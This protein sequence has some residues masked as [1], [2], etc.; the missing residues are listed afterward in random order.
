MVRPMLYSAHLSSAFWPEAAAYA[1]WTLLR[2]VP[3]RASSTSVSP[4]ELLHGA[5]PD[6]APAHQF[7]ALVDFRDDRPANKLAPR[8]RQ[9]LCMGVPTNTSFGTITI[10]ALDT[11]RTIETRDYSVFPGITPGSKL[12]PVN[13]ADAADIASGAGVWGTVPDASIEK[14][15]VVDALL[16]PQGP[17]PLTQLGVAGHDSPTMFSDSTN[18]PPTSPSS[19]PSSRSV[20]NDQDDVPGTGSQP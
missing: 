1:A 7:G 17:S 13:Q 14:L 15:I 6:M 9:G 3:S 10:F 5:P 11:G 20:D 16:E 18:S 12:R 2:T 4:Y 19:P 8:S